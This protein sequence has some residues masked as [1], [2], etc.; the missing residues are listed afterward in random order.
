MAKCEFCGKAIRL[1]FECQSADGRTFGVGRDCVNRVEPAGSVLRV[2]VD[3]KFKEQEQV[4]IRDR[5]RKA[6][7]SLSA[8][9]DF[10]RDQPHPMISGKSMR[11]YVE[12]VFANGGLTA[13]KK[14]C[15]IVEDRSD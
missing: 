1:R 8:R 15:K 2:E 10:L 7:D 4:A 14:V 9:P 11:D 12:F 6:K 13:L 3:K 5:V